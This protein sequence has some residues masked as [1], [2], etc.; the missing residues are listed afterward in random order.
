MTTIK[1]VVPNNEFMTANGQQACWQDRAN[2]TSMLQRRAL[3]AARIQARGAHH[4]HCHV[5]VSVGYPTATRADPPN[6]YGT[7]KPLI[8]GFTHAGIWP[9]DDSEHIEAMTF[10]R[11]TVK[12]D[13]GTHTF[14]FDIEEI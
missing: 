11:D 6:T 12:S 10:R 7:V 4:R 1:V 13:R 3:F 8:D 14:R 2:R 5:T 9:D